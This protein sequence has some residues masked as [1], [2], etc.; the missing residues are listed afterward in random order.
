MSDSGRSGGGKEGGCTV[1]GFGAVVFWLKALGG[2][3][4]FWR[5]LVAGFWL[6]RD[7]DPRAV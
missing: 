5:W 4:I 7:S 1:L 6:Q 3:V 2:A